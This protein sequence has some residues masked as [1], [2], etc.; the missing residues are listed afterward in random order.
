MFHK[1]LVAVALIR[2]ALAVIF[3]APLVILFGAFVDARLAP[4]LRWP[5][6]LLFAYVASAF[7]RFFPSVWANRADD[8]VPVV[9]VAL[10]VLLLLWNAW[11]LVA[12]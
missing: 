12:G 5:Q 9:F 7:A 6:A 4:A 3:V 2:L 8:K 1:R 10:L 11:Y